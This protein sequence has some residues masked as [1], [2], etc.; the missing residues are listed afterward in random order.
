MD[1]RPAQI[2]MG[3]FVFPGEWNNFVWPLI[4]VQ[5]SELRTLPLLNSTLSGA[6]NMGVVMAASFLV[7]LP[8]LAMFIIFQKQFVRGIALTGIKG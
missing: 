1:D 2:A 8:V 6:P 5:S 3:I 4:I 7:S